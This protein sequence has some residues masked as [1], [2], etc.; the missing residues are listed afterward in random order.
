[1][2]AGRLSALT[3]LEPI[4]VDHP[5]VQR[6]GA[7]AV[8]VDGEYVL[9]TRYVHTGV[10]GLP[11]GGI[12]PGESPAEAVRRETFEES[13]V[14]LINARLVEVAG[15][16]LIATSPRGELQD[17][18]AIRFIYRG[19]VPRRMNPRVVE[20]GGSTDAASWFSLAELDE[21]DLARSSRLMIERWGLPSWA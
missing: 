16:R 11:G 5:K 1:M 14:A 6:P 2:T 7:Y 4:D 17:F 10:W 9:L 3:S 18:H 13:G 15:E 8:V 12:D 21:I 20:I 19:G